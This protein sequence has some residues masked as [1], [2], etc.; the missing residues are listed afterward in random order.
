MHCFDCDI[1]FSDSF[2]T[3]DTCGKR[4]ETD[5]DRYFKSGMERMATGE[6]DRAVEFLN[7]CVTLNP[8]HISGR[9]NL[10]IALSLED[11]C[12]EAMEQF[13]AIVS[14]TPDYPGVYTAMG[15]AAFGSYLLHISEAEAL[16]NAMTSFFMMAIEQD[17]HDVDAYFSLGNAYIAIGNAEK[18]IPWLQT[19]LRLHPDS[20]AIYHTLAKALKMMGKNCEAV[21][22]AKKSVQLSNPR[23][24]FWED[25]QGLFSELQQ[26]VLPM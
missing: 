6:I 14:E 16:C 10:G 2:T 7:G 19:A 26:N 21:E 12:D 15:Q 25:I 23:D 9:Y 5:S 1:H 11:R 22:M 4:L 3:C 18:S 20:P 13:S 24:P 8:D 17:P